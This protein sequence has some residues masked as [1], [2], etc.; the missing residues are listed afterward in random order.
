MTNTAKAT[1]KTA[2][3]VVTYSRIS[4]DTAGEGKGV[5]RQVEAC[6]DLATSRGWKIAKEYSDNDISAFSG[7]HR[8]GYTELMADIAAGLVDV[9]VVYQSSRIWRDR[10]ERAQAFDVLAEHRIALVATQGSDFDFSTAQGRM[11]AGIITEFDTAESAVK[12]ERVKA[13]AAQ[14]RA[15]GR[16]NGPPLYGWERHYLMNDEGARVGVIGDVEDKHTADIVRE[17]VDRL[18]AGDSLAEIARD[19][20]LIHI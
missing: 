9:I 13:A 11:L 20:S 4:Q 12:S 17:I 19:L 14:R 5:A 10:V 7:K 15:E 16:T 1:R 18:L 3:R 2:P 6:R 8:P